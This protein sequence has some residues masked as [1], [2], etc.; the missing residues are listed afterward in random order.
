[1]PR[2]ALPKSSIV[3]SPVSVSNRL[4]LTK[5]DGRYSD[6]VFCLLSK[7]AA[8]TCS[9]LCLTGLSHKHHGAVDAVS[10]KHHGAVDIGR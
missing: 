8:S 2:D 7:A 1:M 3:L 6:I 4:S 10:H 9:D 5:L